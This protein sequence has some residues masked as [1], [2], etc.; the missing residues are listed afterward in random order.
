ML[1]VIKRSALAISRSVGY[2]VMPLREV[3]DRDLAIHLGRLFAALKID[4]VLDVGAN[5]GQYRDF[6]RDRVLF[7]GLIISFEPVARNVEKLLAGAAADPRWKIERH[8]L[9]SQSGRAEINVSAESLFSSFRV[10]LPTS[11]FAG[12]I[13]ITHTEAV[14]VETV[15]HVVGQLRERF[16]FKRPYLKLDTQGYDLEVLRGAAGSLRSIPALQTEASVIPIYDEM[17]NYIDTIKFLNQQGFSITGMYPVSRDEKLRLVEFDC[18]MINEA[19]LGVGERRA[20][21]S[22]RDDSERSRPI[23]SGAKAAAKP[24]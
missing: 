6:L 24:A 14:A 9:G 23:A 2:D 16:G 13:D 10:P 22:T 15:D 5:T 8:A 18:V 11:A 19:L 3:K 20:P 4:C 7:D 17:P 21:D 1:K 12:L